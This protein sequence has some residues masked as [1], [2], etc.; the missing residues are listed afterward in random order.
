MSTKHTYSHTSY[1]SALATLKKDKE[2][3]GTVT[4]DAGDGH[5][6]RAYYCTWRKR[7]VVETVMP[8]GVVLH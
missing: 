8:S 3:A 2:R 5:L 7:V 1:K 6:G 4:W